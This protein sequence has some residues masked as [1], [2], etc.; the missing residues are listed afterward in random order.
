M[1]AGW[2]HQNGGFL[3]R[4]IMND[5][6]KTRE[7]LIEEL[8]LTREQLN[9]LRQSQESLRNGRNNLRAL[10]DAI[11]ESVFI[12]KPDGEVLDV[13]RTFARRLGLTEQD[14]IGKNIYDFIPSDVAKRRQTW[15]NNVVQTAKPFDAIDDRSG[16]LLHHHFRPILNQAGDVERLAVYATDISDM[17]KTF[18]ALIESEQRYKAVVDNIEIGISVLNSNM[19]IVEVNRFFRKYFPHVKPGTSQ[20]CYKQYNDPPRSAPCDYCPCVLTFKDG[21]IHEAITE[22]PF[23]GEI[24]HYRLVSSPIMDKHGKVALV[25]ELT[26]DISDSVRAS[27]KLRS[28][29]DKLKSILDNMNDGIYI[30]SHNHDIEYINPALEADF[31]PHDNLKCYQYFDERDEP[32]PWCR[33]PEVFQGRSFNWEWTSHK[34]GKTYDLFETPV[35]NDDGTVSKLQFFHDVTNRKKSEEDLRQ[36]EERL[37]L[38]LDSI[39][40]SDSDLTNEELSNIL[41]ID[42][43]QALMDDFTKLTGAVTAIL[44]LNGNILVQSG[45]QDICLNFH[46]KNPLSLR[47]CLNSDLGQ[48]ENLEPGEVVSYKCMNNLHDV[49]S[50]IFIGKKRVGHVYTGQ[51][52]YDDEEIDV[53]QFEEQAERFGFDQKEYLETVNRTPRVSREK[54][55]VTMDFLSKFTT[56]IAKLSFTNIKLARSVSRLKQIENELRESQEDLKLIVDKSPIILLTSIGAEQVTTYVNPKFY[57]FLGYTEE[58]VSEI[59]TWWRLGYPDEKYRERVKREWTSRVERAVADKTAIEPMEVVVTCKDGSKK[60]IEWGFVSTGKKNIVFGMDLT[61]RKMAEQEKDSLQERLLHA[62]KMEAIGTLAG[63]IAHDFNNLL[64]IVIGYSQLMLDDDDFPSSYKPDLVKVAKASMDGAELVKGLLMFG[65]KAELKMG[66]INLN[67]QIRNFKKLLNRTIPK[68]IEIEL[69]LLN[70]LPV[71]RAD[72]TRIEQVLMNLAVNAR[73]AMP[74]GGKLTFQTSKTFLDDG[75][76]P[77]DCLSKPGNYVHLRVSDTGTGI[78]KEALSRIFDPFFTTKDVGKGTGLGLA[79]VYGIVNQHGGFMRCSSELSKGTVFDIF[80]P[81]LEEAGQQDDATPEKRRALPRGVE[82][83]LIVDDDETVRTLAAEHLQKVGYRVME[84]S[85]GIEALE[86]YEEFQNEIR[87]V[88]LDLI[89][90][91][92]AGVECLSRLLEINPEIRV[93]MAS[94]YSE[95]G[96]EKHFNDLGA[97][98]FITKPYSQRTLLEAVRSVIDRKT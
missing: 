48:K 95:E 20:I 28:E 31:G 46:R 24:R 3:E 77:V 84:A 32:C 12:M 22:T 45:W 94:G 37:R 56:L 74:D 39:L 44:D 49:V 66:P 78:K 90:P 76:L 85:D 34:T 27:R 51:M 21:K 2:A 75:L 55:D 9:D 30:V 68:M 98:L 53:A 97:R 70:D 23:R 4:T 41:D 82:T 80:L 7:Q 61:Q 89:M 26:Q 73:D 63:G 91:R 60:T 50:P 83:V 72:K 71:I 92:M 64:Q 6:D 58:E 40:E 16:L 81:A 10:F 43:V 19:E 13:N 25:V 96:S 47:N 65:R 79:V 36:T 8:N 93:I 87:I 54:I 62:Q 29:M 35:T 57:E 17:R 59:D 69:K 14:V 15:V 42:N 1:D 38:K 86:V 11:P 52:F 5:Y 67:Q 88:V 33:N 18:E